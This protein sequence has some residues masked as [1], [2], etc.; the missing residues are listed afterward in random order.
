MRCP[1]CE[2]EDTRVVDSRPSE[3]G[4][5][6]RRRRECSVCGHRFTTYERAAVT[7]M[8]RK[9]DGRREPYDPDKIV[10]GLEIT[11]ADRPVSRADVAAI[12][13][14][15]DAAAREM[16]SV[17][18]AEEIG[19]IVLE[20]LRDLDEVAYLRFAS[21]H[22]EFQGARDFHRA[23]EALGEEEREVSG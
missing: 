20:G 14:R 9:R 16:G 12:V 22:K 17:I 6:I 4:A 8:V 18:T 2:A 10:R 23:M 21:V 5:A 13:A 3:G 1:L 7:L 11:L 15:V 19:T